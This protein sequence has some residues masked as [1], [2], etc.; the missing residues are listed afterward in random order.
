MNQYRYAVHN[1]EATFEG[2][3]LSHPDWHEDSAECIAENAADYY[4]SE[5]EVNLKCNESI[6]IEIFTEDGSS[7]GLFSVG[8][9]YSPHFTAFRENE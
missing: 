9:K 7:L 8:Y 6:S 5:N 2:V 3:Y 1:D 4:C